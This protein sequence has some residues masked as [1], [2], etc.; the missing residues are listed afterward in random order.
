M[1]AG[2]RHRSRCRRLDIHEQQSA[3]VDIER[4][5]G[6][7]T[8]RAIQYAGGAAEISLLA[9]PPTPACPIRRLG[10]K[11]SPR[12][13][14]PVW[15]KK[16]V[17]PRQGCLKRASIQAPAP[18]PGGAHLCAAYTRFTAELPRLCASAKL[19]AAHLTFTDSCDLAATWLRVNP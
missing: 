6:W 4:I 9:R 18:L 13:E 1:D 19:D 7:T 15:E 12:A 16:T 8:T 11:A 2:Q 10:G 3:W 17:P 5:V 14:P